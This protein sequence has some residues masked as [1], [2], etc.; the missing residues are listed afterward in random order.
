MKVD[1]IEFFNILRKNKGIYSK[2]AEEISQ[3]YGVNYTRQ[4]VR[5]RALE[6][7]EIYQDIIDQY[8]D[9]ALENMDS[10]MDSKDERVKM[11]ASETMLKYLGYRFGLVEKTNLDITSNEE[12]INIPPIKWINESYS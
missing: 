2:T 9:K 10:L 6:H 12:T 3:T 8:V 11:K 7:P 5:Q 1:H 4:A